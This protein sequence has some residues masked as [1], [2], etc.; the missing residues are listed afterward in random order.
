MQVEASWKEAIEAALAGNPSLETWK[1]HF[2]HRLPEFE[3]LLEHWPRKRVGAALEIGCGNGLAAVYF[4]PLVGRIVA[5]DLAEVDHQAHSIG[6]DFARNFFAQMK[7]TNAEVLGCSA[8]KI[9]LPDSSFDLVYGIYCLEHIPDRPAALRETRRVL[10]SGG[11]ALFTVP[12]AAWAVFFPLG[13]YNELFLRILG[14]LKAKFFP[15]P[16]NSAGGPAGA[17]GSAPKVTGA[18]SFFKY[19]PHFPFP[20]P[21][22]A[23]S[24]WPAELRFYRSRNWEALL[25]AAGFSSVEVVPITFV[26]KVARAILPGPLCHAIEKNLKGKT[27]AAPFAQF[28]CLRARKA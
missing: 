8:E 1:G 24:S 9:P 22:G 14:R 13:F 12:G 20:E 11:E 4:S 25:R 23:H 15:T 26:P 3:E 2:R 18:S 17:A 7:L 28:F 27:W 5:S 6:L 19:Y 10:R 21:H 16:N